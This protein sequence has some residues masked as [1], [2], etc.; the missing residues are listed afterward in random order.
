MKG[1]KV[2]FK[3]A[4]AEGLI[5]IIDELAVCGYMEDDDKMVIAALVEVKQRL[6]Q[7]MGISKLQYTM[8]LTPV[9]SLAMRILYTDFLTPD[10]GYMGNKLLQIANDVEKQFSSK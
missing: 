9:Q 10:K 5:K 1:V 8:T 2:E 4:F 6:Y 3:Y 7:R